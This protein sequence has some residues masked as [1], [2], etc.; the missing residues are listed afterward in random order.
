MPAFSV[1]AIEPTGAGDAF[2]AAVIL[3]LIRRNWS[4]LT[5]EDVVFASASGALTT[6]R[7]GAIEALPTLEEV[8]RF[9][10]KKS[11]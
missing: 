7:R 5:R 4:E 8:E 10:T 6:T 9:L 2:H 11:G 3:R 1:D